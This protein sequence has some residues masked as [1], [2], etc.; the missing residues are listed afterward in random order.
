MEWT[1]LF[2]RDFVGLSGSIEIKNT[3]PL[4][5]GE[6]LRGMYSQHLLKQPD[7]SISGYVHF[8]LLLQCKRY[9][10]VGYCLTKRY[11]APL[12]DESKAISFFS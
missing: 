8:Q 1:A 11:P 5:V 10:I 9:N 12:S 7:Y 4:Q 3:N 6:Q 2:V